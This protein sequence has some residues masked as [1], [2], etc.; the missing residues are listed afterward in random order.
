MPSLPFAEMGDFFEII[1]NHVSVMI[2]ILYSTWN[3]IGTHSENHA[4]FLLNEACN[5]NSTTSTL[6]NFSIQLFYY[7]STALIVISVFIFIIGFVFF[8][9]SMSKAFILYSSKLP[10]NRNQAKDRDDEY[11]RRKELLKHIFIE[12]LGVSTGMYLIE[13]FDKDVDKMRKEMGNLCKE[14]ELKELS[15]NIIEINESV[16]VVAGIISVSFTYIGF[17]CLLVSLLIICIDYFFWSPKH[18]PQKDDKN[19]PMIMSM[20]D[21]NDPNETFIY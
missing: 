18:F 2:V 4:S 12:I 3:W 8:L 10:G 11:A 14:H 1:I 5:K 16:G 15:N 6:N 7:N 19:L 21:N 13:F 20:S 9:I 17:V